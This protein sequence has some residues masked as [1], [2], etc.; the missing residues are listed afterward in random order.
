MPGIASGHLRFGDATAGLAFAAT[1]VATVEEFARKRGGHVAGRGG[2]KAFSASWPGFHDGVPFHESLSQRF[3]AEARGAAGSFTANA[4]TIM[5]EGLQ[6]GGASWDWDGS[7][8]VRIVWLGTNLISLCELRYEYTG[9]AH[10]NAAWVGRNFVLEGDKAR[11]LRLPGLFR[12]GVNWT[13]AL[14]ALCLRELRRQKASLALAVTP[15]PAVIKGFTAED[16]S[17]FNVDGRGLIIHFG[18]YTVGSHAE[19]LFSV[20]IPWS[21]LELLLRPDFRLFPEP[22]VRP[23]SGAATSEGVRRKGSP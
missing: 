12:D 18:D 16:L 19:G 9:G 20:L 23:S 17:S 15:A 6:E 14:S 7:L 3:A 4:Y 13:N 11:E 5:W 22:G 2:G 10:G 1:N 8:E 21:E